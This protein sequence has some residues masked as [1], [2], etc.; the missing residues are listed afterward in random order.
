MEFVEPKKWMIED[1]NDKTCA[2]IDCGKCGNPTFVGVGQGF[3]SSGE[4]Y[5]IGEC[6]QC[7]KGMRKLG[8]EKDIELMMEF[9]SD[10]W[11]DWIAFCLEN[12]YKPCVE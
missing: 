2:V 12:D 11:D 10:R 9:R 5:P 3:L 4:P 8:G 1:L 7:L 6:A